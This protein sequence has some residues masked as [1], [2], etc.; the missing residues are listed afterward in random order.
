MA[1]RLICDIWYPDSTTYVI[2]GGMIQFAVH[3]LRAFDFQLRHFFSKDMTKIINT[4]AL[5]F[6]YFYQIFHFWLLEEY[7]N[8]AKNFLNISKK[9]CINLTLVCLYT[10]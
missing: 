5:Y 3:V 4:M 7:V 8:K 2:N 1:D 6:Y 9:Y 10:I